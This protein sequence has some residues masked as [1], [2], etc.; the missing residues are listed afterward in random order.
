MSSPVKADIVPAE[1][2]VFKGAQA[3]Q[4]LDMIGY[5]GDYLIDQGFDGFLAWLDGQFPVT[6]SSTAIRANL[7]ILCGMIDRFREE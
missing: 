4:V 5:M 3:N 1:E 7:V 6:P 2:Y